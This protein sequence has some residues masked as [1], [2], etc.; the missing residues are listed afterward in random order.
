MQALDRQIDRQMLVP[1]QV[2]LSILSLLVA[3]A[4]DL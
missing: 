1:E 2:P 3:L 4:S